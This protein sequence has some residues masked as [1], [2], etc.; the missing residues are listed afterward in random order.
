MEGFGLLGC[1][2]FGFKAEEF[3]YRVGARA[4]IKEGV[5]SLILFC[6][7]YR[8]LGFRL[9]SWS[10]DATFLRVPGSQQCSH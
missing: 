3:I 9:R 6:R 10:P 5:G 7:G 4:V 8:G 2:G 1:R